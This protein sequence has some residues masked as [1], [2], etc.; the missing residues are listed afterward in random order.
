MPQAPREPYTV[1]QGD[2]IASIAARFGFGADELWNAP[3]N[4]SLKD[5]RKNPNVLAPGD[6]VRFPSP[7]DRKVSLPTGATHAL[8]INVPT[9]RLRLKLMQNGAPLAQEP[10]ELTVSESDVREGITSDDGLLQETIPPDVTSVACVLTATGRKLVL[11]V[12]ALDPSSE[13]SGI[14]ARLR[15][16]GAFGGAID[17]SLSDGLT[18]ALKAFQRAMGLDPSGQADD[19]TTRALEKSF[20]C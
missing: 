8:K 11:G 17:G 4:R 6:V 20:G 10:Y 15:A 13:L 1:E 18:A 3:E 7:K 5:L 16:I 14:Q 12:G 2:C 9:V 19:A